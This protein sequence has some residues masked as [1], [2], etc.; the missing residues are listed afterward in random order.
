MNETTLN[1]LLAE[2]QS[3]HYIPCPLS[4]LPV[5][6]RHRILTPTY[7]NYYYAFAV[8]AGLGLRTKEFSKAFQRLQFNLVVQI[9][10]FFVVSG[11]VFGISRSL[12]QM[13]VIVESLGDGM[14]IC[15][16]LPVT[17]SMVVAFT[18]TSGGDEAAAIFNAAFGNMV[19]VFL[20]PV[21]ILMY[22]GVK[23]TGEDGS[24]I[25]LLHVFYK[26]ALK[27]VLPVAIGQVLQK[28]SPSV[29]KFV[30][31]YKYYFKQAQLWSIVF[32]IYT[33]FCR[34]F[35]EPSQGVS[36]S[37]I[38]VMIAIQF[39]QLILVLLLAWFTLKTLFPNQPTL[40][41]MGL[42]G[43]TQ[44]TVSSYGVCVLV[45]PSLNTTLFI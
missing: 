19:G 42:F 30:A 41:V 14:V 8:L 44:K 13:G 2:T 33:V 18:K 21:L 29:V 16:C 6:I 32:I 15:A 23:T 7:F 22:L 40:R 34:T 26:L 12:I 9:Y 27:V 25:H 3:H 17:I 37:D 4:F 5:L 20:S 43:C 1:R 31:K 35:A 11:I 36:V 10:N 45:G 38:F 24:M 28:T 39:C